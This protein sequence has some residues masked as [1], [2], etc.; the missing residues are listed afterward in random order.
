[1]PPTDPTPKLTARGAGYEAGKRK[2]FEEAAELAERCGR[3]NDF[4]MLAK[5]IRA[6]AKQPPKKNPAAVELGRLGG[7][8][9]GPARAAKLTSE[10]RSAAAS[11]AAKARWAAQG[12]ME[13]ADE[14]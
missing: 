13:Q 1:M 3:E 2:A 10:E 11:K 7:K 4:R 6:L 12:Q 8:Q 5:R 9:G 14:M